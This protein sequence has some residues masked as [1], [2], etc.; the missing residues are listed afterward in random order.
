MTDPLA[1]ALAVL[2]GSCLATGGA[3]VARRHAPFAG[4]CVVAAGVLVA[5]PVVAAARGADPATEAWV[6]AALPAGAAGLLAFPRLSLRSWL[7]LLAVALCTAALLTVLA[8]T[9]LPDADRAAGL[10]SGAAWAVV[11][12]LAGHTWWRLERTGGDER[13]RLLW[14]ALPSGLAGLVWGLLTFAAPGAAPVAGALACA[15]VP[16]CLY[17]AAVRPDTVDVRDLLVP[18]LVL[19]GTLFGY[20]ALLASAGAVAEMVTGHPPDG[21]LTLVLAALCALTVNPVRQVL[22]GVVDAVLFGQRPDPLRAASEM[23]EVIGDDPGTALDAVRASLALPYAALRN[24]DGVVAESG[25]EVTS[26]RGVPL[27]VGAGAAAELVVGLR[28]GEVRLDPADEHVL[29]LVAPLLA[30][31]LRARAAA[32]EVATS[33]EAVIHAVEEERR[34]L[35]RDLHDGLGPVLSGIAFTTDAARNTLRDDPDSADAL[36]AALRA[37]AV[38]AIAGI[39]RL[40]YGM[41][42]P[43]LDELGLVPALRQHAT[44]LRTADD[45]ALHVTFAVDGLPD[46]PAAW[47]VAAYR[48]VAA[49]LDNAARHSAADTA[50]VRMTATEGMLLVE[51]R[52]GGAA[53]DGWRPGVGLSAMHERAA[54]LGG[55]LTAG[56][57]PDGGFVRALIPLPQVLTQQST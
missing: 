14:V 4:C 54:E 55:T 2:A 11:L 13:R 49:A 30:Q 23:A 7:D 44:G 1:L 28:A 45:R 27:P 31:A 26:T 48:I 34:R 51:V 38:G 52:D 32:A 17:L 57:G 18:A 43:A 12:V 47:E 8:T 56:P 3:L 20:I 22:R 36:L 10:R 24:G 29:R 35:R 41:R 53:P 42:P 5:V 39:R 33:R 50:C 25:T 21:G 6:L 46:L 19:V 37:E 15:A 16:P 9:T 40:V